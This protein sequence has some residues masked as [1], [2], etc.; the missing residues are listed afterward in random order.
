MIQIQYDTY[1]WGSDYAGHEELRPRQAGLLLAPR[2]ACTPLLRRR[3]G[4]FRAGVG[5]CGRC[6]APVF[7]SVGVERKENDPK[8]MC[9]AP[10]PKWK[11]GY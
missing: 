10:A 9:M 1:F 3:R 2:G 11:N 7:F 8:H 4:D 6:A 5:R